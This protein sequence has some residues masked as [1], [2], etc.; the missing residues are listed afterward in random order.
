MSNILLVR[1]LTGNILQVAMKKEKILLLAKALGAKVKLA[2]L[3]KKLTAE[4]MAEKLGISLRTYGNLERGSTG[5]SLGTFLS[6]TI[7]LDLDLSE[8]MPPSTRKLAKRVKK[9]PSISDDE[10]DF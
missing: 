5:I 9:A 10:V 7:L 2:R 8:I 3:E 1:T 6:A 4:E